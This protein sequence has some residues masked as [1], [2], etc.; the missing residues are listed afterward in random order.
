VDKLLSAEI[1]GGALVE[2]SS[3]RASALRAGV[4]AMAKQQLL[5]VTVLSAVLPAPLTS[6]E[7]RVAVGVTAFEQPDGSAQFLL[8]ALTR[9]LERGTHFHQTDDIPLCAEP[10]WSHTLHFDRSIDDTEVHSP[11]GADGPSE[12]SHTAPVDKVRVY[13]EKP[14]KGIE[15][16]RLLLIVAVFTP[17]GLIGS[18]IV[19]ECAP[20]QPLTSPHALSKVFLI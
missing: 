6:E 16:Q 12:G 14:S 9:A 19:P 11:I 17:S 2:D 8:A 1:R 7:S 3:A 5:E 15:G 10:V 13:R 4:L 18:T 20:V